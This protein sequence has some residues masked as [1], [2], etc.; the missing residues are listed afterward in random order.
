MKVKDCDQKMLSAVLTGV[1][2]AYP[3][4]SGMCGHLLSLSHSLLLFHD[5][6]YLNNVL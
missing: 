4:S 1:N 3:Y 5:L 2:R 6:V